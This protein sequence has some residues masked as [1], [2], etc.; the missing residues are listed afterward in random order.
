MSDT[1]Q[2]GRATITL[3]PGDGVGPE[4][5]AAARLVLDRVSSRWSHRFTYREA[6]I[7]GAAIDATGNAL[8]AETIQLCTS[9][10]AV[11]LGAVGGPKWDDPS[12]AVRPEQ[13]L[14]AI[15]KALGLF[16]NLRPVRA[17]P[18]M[19][20]ASPLKAELLA[21]VDC[22]VVRELTGGIYFGDKTLAPHAGGERATDLC[23]YTTAEVERIVRTACELARARKGR[24]TSVDKANVL[25]TSRLWRRVASRVVRDEFPELVVDHLLV[26]SAAMQLIR[27]PASFDVIVTENMF[28][29][30]LTDEASV[31]AGSIGLLPSAS[32]G[33][34]DSA[35]PYRMGLYEPIHG[36]AP[37]LTGLGVVNPIGT[38]LSAA[39]LLRHSLGLEQ[40]A[41]AVET[42]VRSV[43]A[44]GVGTPDIVSSGEHAMSTMALARAIADEVDVT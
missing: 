40:E 14:L 8:P 16:A 2:A 41:G 28:G 6:L 20:H 11:L 23:V 27:A 25:E 42:A 26:D 10:D 29:D 3:L 34:V 35:R 21:G 13:G 37:T 12:A 17:E 1:V 15:R 39:M 19:I 43:L 9:S 32:L 22:V 44:S 30:I 7:G 5:V 33:P 36:S 38:I 18:S 24:L 31:L 4:V